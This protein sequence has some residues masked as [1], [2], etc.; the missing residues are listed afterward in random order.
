MLVRK[1]YC[2]DSYP[3]GPIT[4]RG[5]SLHGLLGLRMQDHRDS[6]YNYEP[7][8]WQDGQQVVNQS[9]SNLQQSTPKILQE[10]LPTTSQHSL[11]AFPATAFPV[12]S[13]A[14]TFVAPEG[15]D[16]KKEPKLFHPDERRTEEPDFHHRFSNPAIPKMTPFSSAPLL[17]SSP[18]VSGLEYALH[19]SSMKPNLPYPSSAPVPLHMSMDDEGDDDG[20][21]EDESGMGDEYQTSAERLASRRKMKRFRYFTHVVFFVIVG[22]QKTN[23][24]KKTTD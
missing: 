22:K 7:P 12:G 4:K 6:G 5:A 11:A 13:P 24:N 18:R 17:D 23:T 8:T 19:G 16:I 14:S 15:A 2:L 1:P 21:D 10:P 9:G 20:L 3:Q